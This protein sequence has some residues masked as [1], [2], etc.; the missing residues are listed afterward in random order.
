MKGAEKMNKEQI[1]SSGWLIKDYSKEELAEMKAKAIEEAEQELREKQIEE[2]ARDICECYNNDGT[3]YQDDM[4]CD[5]KCEHM[6]E[7]QFLYDKGYRKESDVVTEVLGKVQEEIE[8]ALERNYK[9]RQEH[10]EKW[11]DPNAYIGGNF[12]DTV[13]GKILALRGIAD[14]IDEIEKKYK[15]A[16]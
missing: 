12:V 6:T 16:E 2:M 13:D 7:A 5:L 8:L 1:K 4:P 3:C 14:F 15:G 10:L 9:A 11:K